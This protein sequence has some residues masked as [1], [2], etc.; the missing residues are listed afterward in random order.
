MSDILNFRLARAPQRQVPKL[1]LDLYPLP[2]PQ[3]DNPPGDTVSART[4]RSSGPT[5]ANAGRFGGSSFLAQLLTSVT[6][7]SRSASAYVTRPAFL[8]GGAPL[9]VPLRELDS[10]L[11]ANGNRVE[12]ADISK[13]LKKKLTDI[14]QA[15]HWV[16]MR[17]ALA[18]SLIASMLADV[19][20]AIRGELARLIL[21]AGLLEA[22]IVQPPQV[23]TKDDVFNQLRWRTIVIPREIL[24]LTNP[25]S[26]LARRYGF[27]DY[28]LV[29]EEW[30]EYRAG[31]I[32]HIENA[33]AG[34]FVTQHY[35]A[36]ADGNDRCNGERNVKK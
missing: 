4:R 31:E 28:Y 23:V 36:N 29:R 7:R 3:G 22:L 10:W 9:D 16:P 19:D 8:G 20:P 12:P 33:L 26:R 27:S 21:I 6:T 34:N 17:Q 2:A 14:V 5:P 35:A 18:D 13:F 1:S 30:N 25:S 32:A 24:Q 11:T 15:P